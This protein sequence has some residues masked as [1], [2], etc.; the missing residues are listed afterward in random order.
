PLTSM[1]GYVDLIFGGT[2]GKVPARFKDPLMKFQVSTKRLIRIV[3]ALLDI[4]QF[5][6]GKEVVALQPGID[7]ES[8]IKEVIEELAFE[9][10]NRGL[11]LKYNKE[12]EVPLIK[13]DSEKLKVAL[14]N[15][16]DNAIKYTKDGGI[17]LTLK[18]SGK[19]ALFQVKDT[20]IGLEPEK[21]KQ[22]FTSAFI[23]G[24][25]AKKVHGF[26]RGIGV[27]ITGHIIRAHKGKI[28]AESEGKGKGTSFFVQLS[29]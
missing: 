7:F 10:K 22:L 12:G 17:T 27:Y 8:L 20:G 15:I 3:N 4:S 24:K 5:Q 6:M 9:V 19:E 29:S 25:E 1:I 28:W 11:Y 26:G 13:A 21:A 23:R 2:Y 16:I 18:K 14:F